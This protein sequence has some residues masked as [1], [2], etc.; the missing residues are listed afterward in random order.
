MKQ[1]RRQKWPLALALSLLV[2]Q[3]LLAAGTA[4]MANG[5]E[6][7]ELAWLGPQTVRVDMSTEAGYMVLRD[8]KTYLVNPQATGG[9]PPVME[10]GDMMQGLA[11]TL[12]DDDDLDAATSPL[13]QRVESVTRTGRTETVAGIKG[14]VYEVTFVNGK[15]ETESRPVVL[16]DDPLASE[17]TEAYFA[18]TA[19]MIGTQRIADFTDALPKDRRGLLRVGDDLVVQGISEDAPAADAFELPAEPM[20]MGDMMKELLK[21][22]NR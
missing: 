16:T 3:P 10:V 6:I 17:M 14:D 4:T 15:G 5:H 7:H 2:P 18:L 13:S 22:Q 19:S 21:Q 12:A 9:M 11:E 1:Y 8:G 20:N